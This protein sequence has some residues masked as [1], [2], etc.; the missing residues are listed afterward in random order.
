MRWTAAPLWESEWAHAV[1]VR[2]AFQASRAT[3]TLHY[4]IL[5]KLTVLHFYVPLSH[6]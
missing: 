5:V 1:N 3:G 6:L 2:L 4:C